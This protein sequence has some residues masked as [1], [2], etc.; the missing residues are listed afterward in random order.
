MPRVLPVTASDLVIF[1]LPQEGLDENA[2]VDPAGE[3]KASAAKVRAHLR[4][5]D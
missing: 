1:A 5:S 2:P 4:K 3:K